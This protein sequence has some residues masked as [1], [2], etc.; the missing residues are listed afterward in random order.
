MIRDNLTT[1]CRATALNTGAAGSYLIGDVVPLGDQRDIG[2][3]TPLYL[4]VTMAVTATSGGAATGK[5]ALV[6]DSQAAINPATATVHMETPEFAVADMSAGT[7]LI[8]VSIPWQGPEYETYLGLV[9]T[10][11]TAA[12]TAGAINAFLTMTPQT[13]NAYPEYAGL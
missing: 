6:S 1:F 10:T 9:Q 5:F 4:V 2:L 3:H 13:N 8:T 12:F 11:G 7:N